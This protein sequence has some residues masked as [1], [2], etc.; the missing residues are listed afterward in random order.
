[1]DFMTYSQ[2]LICLH[3]T[4]FL[5]LSGLLTLLTNSLILVDVQTSSLCR[6]RDDDNASSCSSNSEVAQLEEIGAHLQGTFHG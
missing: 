3:T 1:M 6:A 5:Y 4:I 2:K